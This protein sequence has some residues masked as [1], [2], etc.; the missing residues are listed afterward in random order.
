M[1]SYASASAAPSASPAPSRRLAAALA[2]AALSLAI[3]GLAWRLS[4]PASLLAPAAL[5]CVGLLA[6]LGLA[7][8]WDEAASPRGAL[9]FCVCAVVVGAA[10][11]SGL[12]ADRLEPA[13]G[14]GAL[15][16]FGGALYHL[17]RQSG[18]R[19]RPP[20]GAALLFGA[21]LV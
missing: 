17:A 9:A 1:S 19:L 11:L 6:T 7:A 10:A 3:A 2:G 21:A 15:G 14:L 4:P 5:G 8:T 13:F 18:A 20:G 16:L 12:D